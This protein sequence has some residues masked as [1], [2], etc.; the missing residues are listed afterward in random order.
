MKKYIV[1]LM[2]LFVVHGCSAMELATLSREDD[3]KCFMVAKYLHKYPQ[4]QDKSEKKSIDIFFTL[5]KRNPLSQQVRYY[6]QV[7]SIKDPLDFIVI[8]TLL[9]TEVQTLIFS[10]LCDINKVIF[11]QKAIDTF[12]NKFEDETEN[13]AG[14]VNLKENYREL[15]SNDLLKLIERAKDQKQNKKYGRL[16]IDCHRYLDYPMFNLKTMNVTEKVNNF[17]T[18]QQKLIVLLSSESNKDN[19]KAMEVYI[20][21][22]DRLL[23][24]RA[25]GNPA[26]YRIQTFQEWN[27]ARQE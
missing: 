12:K 10:T 2:I 11:V 23:V 18:E 25:F 9:P 6:Q 26:Q 19:D 13:M 7:M 22:I 3:T 14:R 15:I 17:I 4:G 8:R 27:A 24:W 5:I 20:Q 1:G 21:S 16:I